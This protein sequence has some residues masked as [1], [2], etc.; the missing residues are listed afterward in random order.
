M[1]QH[2]WGSGELRTYEDTAKEF[3]VTRERVRQIEK[4]F[5]KRISNNKTYGKNF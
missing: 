2:K 3:D 4:V 5:L 1:M